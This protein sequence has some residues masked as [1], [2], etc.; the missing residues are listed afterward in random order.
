MCIGPFVTSKVI[1]IVITLILE[2][3]IITLLV[4]LHHPLV[5]LRFRLR[6]LTNMSGH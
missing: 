1:I 4:A 5:T 6:A 3:G 2:A